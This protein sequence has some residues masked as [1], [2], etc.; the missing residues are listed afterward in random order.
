M[1]AFTSVYFFELSRFNGLQPIQVKFF[2]FRRA[3]RKALQRLPYH[4]DHVS[5]GRRS[6]HSIRR[7]E[8][9]NTYFWFCQEIACFER[10]V[11]GRDGRA[12]PRTGKRTSRPSF[13][14]MLVILFLVVPILQAGERRREHGSHCLALAGCFGSCDSAPDRWESSCRLCG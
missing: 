10:S 8:K 2:C 11:G 1:L 7:R 14:R 3:P 9:H 13:G 12:R 4:A 6:T 5:P